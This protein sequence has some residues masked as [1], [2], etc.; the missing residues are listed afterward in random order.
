MCLLNNWISFF[1]LTYFFSVPNVTYLFFQFFLSLHHFADIHTKIFWK[2]IFFT[3]YDIL[4]KIYVS[5][6]LH[7]SQI[8]IF[9]YFRLHSKNKTKLFHLLLIT[10]F[11]TFTYYMYFFAIFS[12]SRQNFH[13]SK[14]T[15]IRTKQKVF[16]FSEYY[17]ISYLISYHWNNYVLFHYVLNYCWRLL[18]TLLLCL[19]FSVFS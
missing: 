8:S 4:T 11:F 19:K 17:V 1:V 3:S 10:Y 18:L 2:N 13:F 6:F 9:S 14:L 7:T 5:A 15:S 12:E 16:Q